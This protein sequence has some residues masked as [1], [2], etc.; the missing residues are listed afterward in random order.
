MTEATRCFR[1]YIFSRS[2]R[3]VD[4]PQRIQ[5][6]TIRD[7][8]ARQDLRFLLSATEYRMP[9]CFMMLD[10]LLTHA[11]SRTGLIAFSMFGLPRSTDRRRAA[12]TRALAR[13]MPIHFALEND[14]IETQTDFDR[15]EDMLRIVDLL[16]SCTIDPIRAH[17][18]G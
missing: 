11:P 14:R 17:T 4:W 18:S 6:L 7:Y 13:D 3:G 5:N 1:G 15:I 8:A 16:P 12:L 9:G 10:N 2:I